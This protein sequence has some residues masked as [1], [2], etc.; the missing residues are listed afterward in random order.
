MYY[1]PSHTNITGNELADKYA[2][3][4]AKM[5]PLE[6]QNSIPITLSNLKSYLKKELFCNWYIKSSKKYESSSLRQRILFNTKSKLKL[7]TNTPRS[8]Q[9]LFSQYRCDR[10]ESVGKYLRKLG[11]VKNPSY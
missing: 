5:Y 4:A 9:T 6:I 11:Y 7:R 1:T 8:L 10:S 2:K 3:Q